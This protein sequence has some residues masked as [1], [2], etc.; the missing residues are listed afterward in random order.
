[1]AK[2]GSSTADAHCRFSNRQVTGTDRLY[3]EPLY[4]TVRFR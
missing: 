2:A 3:D 4:L 1:V